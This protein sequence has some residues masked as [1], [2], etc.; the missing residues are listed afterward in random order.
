MG[1]DFSIYGH[2]SDQD[3]R[4]R[5]LNF[6]REW[7]GFVWADLPEEENH[8]IEAMYQFHTGIRVAREE[9]PP[10]VVLGSNEEIRLARLETQKANQ[11]RLLTE[12]EPYEPESLV[13]LVLPW[14]PDAFVFDTEAGGRLCHLDVELLGSSGSWQ[15]TSSHWPWTHE[16]L[17]EGALLNLRDGFQTRIQTG[18]ADFYVFAEVLRRHF[19][20]DC[21]VSADYDVDLYA[22]IFSRMGLLRRIG[23]VAEKDLASIAVTCSREARAMYIEYSNEGERI[24]DELRKAAEAEFLEQVGPW[25]KKIYTATNFPRHFLEEIPLF[26]L[27]DYVPNRLHKHSLVED[28]D[29]F[30]VGDEQIRDTTL[31]PHLVDVL[32]SH[33]VIQVR[34]A[35]LLAEEE[36]LAIKGITKKDLRQLQEVALVSLGEV[37]VP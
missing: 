19:L 37:S 21:S 11:R 1:C 13:G 35:L 20:S 26:G 31:T 23:E 17:A 18:T 16:L 36:V 22:D 6:V 25:E 2:Q 7:M 29:H 14:R 12:S 32:E 24:R 8:N 4:A 30:D 5:C 34:D 28:F 10:G 27:M 33:G 15:R 3:I 9:R